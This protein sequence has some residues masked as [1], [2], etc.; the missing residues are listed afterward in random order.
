VYARKKGW[1]LGT[2]GTPTYWVR[3]VAGVKITLGLNVNWNVR[4]FEMRGCVWRT[5]FRVVVNGFPL[6]TKKFRVSTVAAPLRVIVE[7]ASLD[8]MLFPE[9]TTPLGSTK[10]NPGGRV[11]QVYKRLPIALPGY[12]AVIGKGA[13]DPPTEKG[14]KRIC[15]PGGPG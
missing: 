15:E 14:A 5:D 1:L 7:A 13:T 9:T 11:V 12:T 2:K 4:L 8:L 6:A 3:T 10:L